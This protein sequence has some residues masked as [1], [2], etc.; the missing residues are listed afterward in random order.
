MVGAVSADIVT[1]DAIEPPALLGKLPAHGD[2]IARG[3]AHS[4][5]APLDGW[6]SAWI[7]LARERLEEQ[8]EDAYFS[9]AP[10]LFEGQRHNAVL[11]PSLDSI[12]RLFP[13]LALASSE[14]RTQG[15]YDTLIAAIETGQSGD[16]LRSS[17]ADLPPE[18]G[19]ASDAQGEWF[20]PDG[21]DQV[22][23]SPSDAAG[24]SDVREQLA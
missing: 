9:A 2:F 20:L 10:W 11:M 8:F 6:M 5:R 21:A 7:E 1:Q 12:G 3:I 15:V 18:G 23:P 19:Q 24:W 16:D 14:C 4:A 17:L 13:I 22:L